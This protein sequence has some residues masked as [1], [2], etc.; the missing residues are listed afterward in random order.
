MLVEVCICMF[1]CD[2]NTLFLIWNFSEEKFIVGC[3]WTS[4]RRKQLVSIVMVVVVV[5]LLVVMVVVVVMMMVVVVMMV[6]VMMMVIVMV[7]MV[8]VMVKVGRCSVAN[9]SV[10]NCFNPSNPGGGDG[11]EG[12]GDGRVEG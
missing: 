5:M 8:V 11:V 4:Y 6:V 2:S 12:W 10:N 1:W 9:R 3:S 7:M